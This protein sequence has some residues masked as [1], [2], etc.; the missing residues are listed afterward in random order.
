MKG[1]LL[2]TNILSELRRPK[3]NTKV[4]SFITQ[5]HNELLF[6]SVIAFAEIRFGIENVTDSK[7][8]QELTF[9]LNSQLRPFFGNRVLAIDEEVMLRWRVLLESGRKIG[10]TYSQPDLIIAAAALAHDLTL[11]TRNTKDFE[12]TGVKLLNLFCNPT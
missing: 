5:Q 6:I 3:P 12:T 1:W 10:R 7:K 11:V 8:R 2:D 9:W 4:V